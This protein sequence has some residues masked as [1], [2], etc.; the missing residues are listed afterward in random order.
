MLSEILAKAVAGGRLSPGDGLAL[1]ESSDLAALGAAADAV[2]RRRHPEPFRTYNVDRNI[3]YT[4][5]CTSGCRFCAFSRKLGDTD[6]YVLSRDELYQQDR[7]D[8]R[9][10][11]RSDSAPGRAAPGT[12]DR[13]VR[14]VARRHQAALPG[15]NVHGFSPP[16]IHH[17][18]AVSGLPV[19]RRAGAL[20]GRRA[21]VAAGR[22]GGDSGRSR[23]PRGEPVQGH[24]RPLAGGLPHVARARRAGIGHDD[25][26]PRRDALPTGS[27]TWSGCANCRTRRAVLPLSSPGRFSRTIRR[28]RA[29]RRPA[30]FRI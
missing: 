27:N 20:E 10:R 18:A 11:R 9:A 8:D 2:T 14:G 19:A 24:G 4:N 26:R 5:V 17:I 23:P 16:E 3:N 1:L 6:A 7:G 12:Q 21:G 15:I 29:C 25:V 22:R 30:R 28:W 13:V